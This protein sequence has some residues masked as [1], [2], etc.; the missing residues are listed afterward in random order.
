MSKQERVE[1]ANCR[2]CSKSV[3][4]SNLKRHEQICI[5]SETP[6][7]MESPPLS[8]VT[9]AQ[10]SSSVAEATENIME[11]HTSYTAD[12][13][14]EFL[15]TSFP[16]IPQEVRLPVVIAATTAAR[17]ASVL[18]N[19]YCANFQSPDPSKRAFAAESH[20]A[21]SFW[22]LG[23]RMK[24]RF[25]KERLQTSNPSEVTVAAVSAQSA[26]DGTVSAIVESASV[27]ENLLKS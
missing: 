14:C 25:V 7:D 17:R 19:V 20:S 21:L 9:H 6:V 26:T 10:L 16:E 22:A 18:H 1:Q 15:R 3:R 8:S 2:F 5:R 12:E 23:L 13:L 11:L 24:M 4:R 27:V